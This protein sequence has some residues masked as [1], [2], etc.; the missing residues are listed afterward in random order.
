MRQRRSWLAVVVFVGACGPA[1]GPVCEAYVEC[2]QA[3]EQHTAAAFYADDGAC[4]VNQE[5]AAVCEQSCA[6]GFTQSNMTWP[7]V[8]ACD[9]GDGLV[10]TTAFQI[11]TSSRVEATSVAA[12]GPCN[13]IQEASGTLDFSPEQGDG[14]VLDGTLRTNYVTLHW[15]ADCALVWGGFSCAPADSGVG[16]LTTVEGRFSADM[17]AVTAVATVQASDQGADGETVDCDYTVELAG[18]P[19]G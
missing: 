2:L 6:E 3:A 14:F 17:L 5:S 18:S 16:T 19:S 11:V 8:E 9:S 7:L 15:T 10:S 13:D 12:T 4:W 1:I